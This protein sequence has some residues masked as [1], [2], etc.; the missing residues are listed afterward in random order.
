[1]M[2]R[3]GRMCV[4]AECGRRAASGSVV[5]TEHR[6]SALGEQTEREIATMTR[7]MSALAKLEGEEEKREAFRVF[8][9]QVVRGDYAAVF[10]SKMLTMLNS[11]G[12]EG[13]LK[14]MIGAMKAGAMRVLLEEEQPSRAAHAL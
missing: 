9:Q 5:C 12:R 7:R 13:D 8:R 6:D 1:M 4:V 10:S 14:M 2:A 3:K 11:A